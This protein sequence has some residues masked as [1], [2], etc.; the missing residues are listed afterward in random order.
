M[1]QDFARPQQKRENNNIEN[2]SNYKSKVFKILFI[3]S[4]YRY[5]KLLNVFLI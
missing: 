5:I 4:L 1:D 3:S 2:L